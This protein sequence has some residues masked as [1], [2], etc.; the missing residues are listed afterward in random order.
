MIE[1]QRKRKKEKARE[2]ERI[3]KRFPPPLMSTKIE[4]LYREEEREKGEGMEESKI[5]RKEKREQGGG[6]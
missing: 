1:E 5:V 2:K 3:G 4:R 6:G